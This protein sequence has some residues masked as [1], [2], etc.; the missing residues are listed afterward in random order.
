MGTITVMV[1]SSAGAQLYPWDMEGGE[2]V[3]SPAPARAPAPERAHG[4]APAPGSSAPRRRRHD[5]HNAHT[6]PNQHPPR[7]EDPKKI[8]VAGKVFFMNNDF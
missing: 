2:A 1:S 6:Q 4:P 7:D 5:N 8:H 3:L